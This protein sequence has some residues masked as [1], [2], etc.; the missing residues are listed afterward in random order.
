MQGRFKHIDRLVLTFVTLGFLLLV[1]FSVLVLVKNKTLTNRTYYET[2][3]DSANGLASNPAIFFKGFEIGRI[4]EFELVSDTNEIRVKFFIYQ[5]YTHKIVKYAVISRIESALLSN[6][7][8][9]EIL[10]PRFDS[11]TQPERLLEGD[12]VPFINSDLGQTYAKKG[13]IV[14]KLNS[15]DTVLNSANSVLVNLQRESN[16]NTGELFVILQKFSKIADSLVNLSHDAETSEII[17]E[18]K[19]AILDLQSVIAASGATLTE[20]KTTIVQADR[21][22]GNA[23]KVVQHL[24]QLLINYENPAEIIATVTGNKIPDTIGKFDANL[25]YLEGI[26]EEIHQQREQLGSAIVSINNTLSSLDKTLEG[27]NN[28]PLI[29]DGIESDQSSGLSIEINEN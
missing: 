3:L 17:P 15:I 4:D 9:Y 8:E 1:S 10:P 27:V 5:N 7:N 25:F 11:A 2:L 22:L 12:L 20:T 16:A 29:K 28:N 24:D 18:V 23:N 13:Q 19:K 14:Q 21:L 6:S 26:L